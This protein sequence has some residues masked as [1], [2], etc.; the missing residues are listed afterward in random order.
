[1]A[2]GLWPEDVQVGL[3]QLISNE[4]NARLANREASI[5]ADAANAFGGI[6]DAPWKKSW[7]ALLMKRM[8]RYAVDNGFEQIAWING[9]Q[10]NGGQ[11]GGDGSF[12]YERNLVNVTNDLLK[13][14]GTKVGP[15]DMIETTF[16]RQEFSRR[17]ELGEDTAER[18]AEDDKLILASQMEVQ[19][20][21]R[22][23][24]NL[25]MATPERV[26]AENVLMRA[27]MVQRESNPELVAAERRSE[28]RRQVSGRPDPARPATSLGI[29]NGFEITPQLAEAAR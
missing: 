3:N 16:G 14:F 26:A 9:N 18:R 28:L 7:D 24:I 2:S 17:Q 12:F 15:V 8:I 13:K 20:L 5:A 27:R 1:M 23:A 21:Y 10:Q 6:P 4:E 19:D 29:Q 11:T 25:P 22:E